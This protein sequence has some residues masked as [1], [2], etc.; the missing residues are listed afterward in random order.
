[1]SR[2]GQGPT[3]FL[4]LLEPFILG[5]LLHL[6]KYFDWD[7]HWTGKLWSSH[8]LSQAGIFRGS[9][10]LPLMQLS[11]PYKF[12]YIKVGSEIPLLSLILSLI[13]DRCIPLVSAV[14]LSDPEHKIFLQTF[15]LWPGIEIFKTRYSSS[16][17][18]AEILLIKQRK[19][20]S[21]FYLSLQFCSNLSSWH[22]LR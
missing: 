9:L 22:I 17:K 1:M 15:I 3:Y 10:K 18:A 8:G 20:H 21:S 19:P 7:V 4:S 12:S 11:L 16:R 5:V 14:T 6:D 2:L 13:T